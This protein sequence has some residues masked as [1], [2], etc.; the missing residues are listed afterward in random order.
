[1]TRAPQAAVVAMLMVVTIIGACGQPAP[2]WLITRTAATPLSPSSPAPWTAADLA[3]APTFDGRLA[4]VGTRVDPT[5]T[6]T[7]WLRVTGELAGRTKPSLVIGWAGQATPLRSVPLLAWLHPLEWRPGDVVELTVP[8]EPSSSSSAAL[9]LGIEDA[10]RRWA[11]EAPAGRAIHDGCIEVPMAASRARAVVGMPGPGDPP[12]TIEVRRRQ[13]QPITIDGALLEADWQTAPMATLVPWKTGAPLSWG[14]TVKLL[15]DETFLYVGFDVDDDD[16]HSPY[17]RR[18]DPLYDGEALELFIDADGDRDVYVEL[19]SSSKDV[20]FD[21]AFS[22]GARQHMDTAWNIDVVTATMART[23]GATPGYS[24]EW[25]IPIAAL[26]DIPAGEPHT[27]TRWQANIFRLE[28]RRQGEMVTSTEASA[29][30]PPERG[31]FHALDRF[32]TLRF[33]D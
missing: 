3:T 29:L 33:S 10:G 14:T 7:V 24:Q 17:T 32:G 30:S 5:G 12:G 13:R 23:G 2:A 19:Q 15:W 8:L 27:G 25:Q 21:A 4:L 28:R 26:K 1:V 11:V 22:G 31:D 9:L 20:H 16:P 18:D 6:L